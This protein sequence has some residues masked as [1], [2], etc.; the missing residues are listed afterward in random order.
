MIQGRD[1]DELCFFEKIIAGKQFFCKM[2]TMRTIRVKKDDD[3]GLFLFQLIPA[4]H[5]T[6]CYINDAEHGYGRKAFIYRDAVFLGLCKLSAAQ[7]KNGS[8]DLL[9]NIFL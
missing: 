5:S 2:Y 9:Q 1:H 8:K 3:H 7:T 4:K 6:V